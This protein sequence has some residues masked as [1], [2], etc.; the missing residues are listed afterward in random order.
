MRVNGLNF[1]RV[2][3]AHYKRVHPS[4]EAPQS[5]AS[6]PTGALKTAKMAAK[7]ALITRTCS[8]VFALRGCDRETLGELAALKGSRAEICRILSIQRSFHP[9]QWRS[10]GSCPY[11]S[12]GRSSWTS[13]KFSLSGGETGYRSPYAVKRQDN[14]RP[15]E[16]SAR[17]AN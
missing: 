7:S 4:H 5:A 8:D 13:A 1:L 16:G 9:T 17:P 12:A 2:L 14:F 11:L 6:A 10:E 15:S 3:R